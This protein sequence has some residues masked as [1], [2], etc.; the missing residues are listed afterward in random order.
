MHHIIL[1]L[2]H[3]NDFDIAV[4]AVLNG[5]RV[6]V[7]KGR[8][9]AAR[10]DI[11]A[12]HRGIEQ[13]DHRQCYDSRRADRRARDPYPFI[14]EDTHG[15]QYHRRRTEQCDQDIPRER[16]LTIRKII[17][18]R[19]A[20]Q[21]DHRQQDQISPPLV[22]FHVI[23]DK[24]HREAKERPNKPVPVISEQPPAHTAERHLYQIHQRLADQEKNKALQGGIQV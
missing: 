12:V 11:R 17:H 5:D 21:Q 7:V 20:R 22:L 14:A 13:A 4:A 15:I 6:R 24:A 2:F 16:K 3:I 19:H 18:I 10:E 8:L 9:L 23:A 1:D